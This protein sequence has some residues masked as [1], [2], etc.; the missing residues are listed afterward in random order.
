LWGLDPASQLRT[1]RPSV[2]FYAEICRSNSLSSEMIA[3]YAPGSFER[4]LP[5]G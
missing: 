1:R 5:Q 3:K 4:I 2:D